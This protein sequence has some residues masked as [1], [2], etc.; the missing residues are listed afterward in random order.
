MHI[1]TLYIKKNVCIYAY[2]NKYISSIADRSYMQRQCQFWVSLWS[3]LNWLT[4]WLYF[5][6]ATIEEVVNFGS[7]KK[8]LHFEVSCHFWVS[9]SMCQFWVSH[10]SPIVSILG[11]PCVHLLSTG[12]P[13]SRM[14]RFIYTW[15]ISVRPSIDYTAR[16]P[17]PYTHSHKQ[18]ATILMHHRACIRS[19]N[20]MQ[21]AQHP[22]SN[23]QRATYTANMQH[24]TWLDM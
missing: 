9:S 17:P 4:S 16:T 12:M 11:R 5:C 7:F 19:Y 6:S 22:T 14:R 15:Y 8:L 24:T 13:A 18:H 10:E 20:N 2:T 21:H 3:P 23:I 1:Y